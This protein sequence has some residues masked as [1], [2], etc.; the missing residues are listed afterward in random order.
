MTVAKQCIYCRSLVKRGGDGDHVIPRAF[1]EFRGDKHFC[2]VCAACNGKVGRSEEVLVRCSPLALRLEYAIPHGANSRRQK[3]NLQT[4]ARG[5]P[6]PEAQAY[7]PEGVR[8]VRRI[9]GGN[10]APVDQ[11]VVFDENSQP[12]FLVLDPNMSVKTLRQKVKQIG[13]QETRPMDLDLAEINAAKY[14]RLLKHAFP[15]IKIQWTSSVP[16]GV[17]RVRVMATCTYNDHY[18]RAIAKIALHYFLVYS[19]WYSGHEPCFSPIRDFI[20]NGG[21]AAPFFAG[22]SRFGTQQCT[23][24]FVPAKWHHYLA[25]DESQKYVVAFVNLFVGP[26]MP[27]GVEHH[28]KLAE[29]PSKIIIPNARWAHEFAYDA[30]PSSGKT[31]G[32]VVSVALTRGR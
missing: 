17:H 16:A 7:M 22:K 8:R 31:V 27:L 9:G 18:F 20:M 25:A 28:I 6:A 14:E 23:P 15:N 24:G 30:S 29:L 26:S 3:R 5:M 32:E 21:D 19:Q 1:G 4:G 10:V 11:L 13:V 2:G 12:H